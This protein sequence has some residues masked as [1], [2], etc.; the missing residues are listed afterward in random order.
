MVSASTG[1]GLDA[2]GCRNFMGLGMRESI[3][4]LH[5]AVELGVNFLDTADMY[6]SGAIERLL[7]RLSE[8]RWDGVVLATKFAR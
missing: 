8:G 3:R 5:R 6:G 1:W 2:W 4:T 7:G